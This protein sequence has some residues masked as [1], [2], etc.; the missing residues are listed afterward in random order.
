MAEA[1]QRLPPF[2]FAI[3][4]FILLGHDR[5]RFDL[6]Q[7]LRRN[8]GRDRHHRARG[9][10]VAEKFSMGLPNFFPIRDVG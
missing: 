7:H 5:V 10:N 9:T 8:Q 3:H 1:R 4:L 2:L 6:Q